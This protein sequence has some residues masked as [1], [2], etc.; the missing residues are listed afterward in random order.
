[1]DSQTIEDNLIFSPEEM[2]RLVGRVRH[3]LGGR[4]RGFRVQV[5]GGGLIL[6]GRSATFYAK[7]LAQHAVMQATELPILANDI[8]VR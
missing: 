7:Q 1:M 4:L 8:E 3:Q 6:H 2:E 5:R